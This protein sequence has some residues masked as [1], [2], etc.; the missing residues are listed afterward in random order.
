MGIRRSIYRQPMTPSGIE[1]VEKGTMNWLDTEM[2]ANFNTG[3]V[4]QYLDEKNRKDAFSV[5][6]WSWWKVLVAIAVGAL[7]AIVNQYVGLKV[8]MVVGGSWYV[9][10]LL[11]MWLRWSPPTLNIAATAS[12]GAAYICTG[13]VFT[14]PAIYILALDPAEKV[15]GEFLIS[16]SVITPIIPVAIIATMISGILGVMY[17]IV[18]RR[19]W[20]VED[21]LP[22]PGF[23]ATVKLLDLSRAASSEATEQAKS[24]IR[25]AMIWIG[26]AGALTFLRDF[27]LFATSGAFSLT[28]GTVPILEWI[29]MKLNLVKYYS[30]GDLVF[31]PTSHG[32]GK[33]TFLSLTLTPM[34]F[35]VGWFMKA[36]TA[37]LIFLGTAFTWWIAVPIAVMTHAP[38]FWAN[39]GEYFDVAYMG[40]FHGLDLSGYKDGLYLGI[41]SSPALA[42]YEIVRVMAIGTILGG[43][44]TALVR[45]LPIFKTV[46]KDL[47]ALGGGTDESKAAYIRGKG[48][49]EWPSQ[50]I[51]IVMVF[52]F[53]LVSFAFII[54]GFPIIQSI[55][56]SLMMV[57][58]TFILGAIAVK[59]MGETG[60]EPISAT[61][62]LV[63]LLLMV[64]FYF[65]LPIF[66]LDMPRSTV[67]V[68]SLL[69][70][71]VFAGAI[72]MSGDVVMNFKNGLYCGN[73][74]SDLVKADTPGI[75]PG[76]ILS[77]IAAVIFSIGL[78]NHT[79]NLPAPQAHAFT[80]FV[81]GI[82]AGAIQWKL[83][84]AGFGIGVFLELLIGMG[85]AFGLG[86]YLPIGIQIPMLAG[87][88][89]RSVWEKRYLDRNAEKFGW[90]ENTRTLK[91]VGS[92]MMATGMIVGEAIVGTIVA[93]WLVI[94][95]LG[96]VFG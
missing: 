87:G 67:I 35:G 92:F 23:E 78:A 94:P 6:A 73:R 37:I 60:S 74:P 93:L 16:E 31:T 66:G 25:Q 68:M 69:G 50:H 13:F 57:L 10:Y 45:M 20:L 36:R 83:F 75:I 82:I 27:P 14:F 51:I 85:T 80:I 26:G 53:I 4:E 76:A 56:F 19:I 21:P 46:F 9:V 38:Y 91:L 65:I 15:G 96:T 70:T 41:P 33:F 71:T 88:V 22:T 32:I 77:G 3:A 24:S 79:L 86:M 29:T 58:F 2:F 95:L 63:L 12:N 81:K 18:F 47:F 28:K 43:G 72:S 89:A 64:T 7:F 90:D 44:M 11:G 8:G 55:I 52:T 48:W 42:A 5:K 59:V 49:Y 30:A 62:F 17:F 61:S 34:M 40:L 84:I 1:K 54:G 39:S